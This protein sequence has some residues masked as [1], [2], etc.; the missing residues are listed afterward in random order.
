MEDKQ[1]MRI[2]MAACALTL[3]AGLNTG[4]TGPLIPKIAQ[5]KGIDLDL[6][7]SIVSVSACGSMLMLLLGKLLCE[8]LGSRNSLRLAAVIAGIGMVTVSFGPGLVVL[9]IGAF[10]IGCGT[11][12]NSIASTTSV[13]LS[14][15]ASSAAALNRV[16]LFFGIGA[17]AGPLIAWAGLSSHWSY[18][19]VYLFGAAFAFTCALLLKIQNPGKKLVTESEPITGNIKKPVLWLFALV[20]YLYVGMEVSSAAWLFTFLQKY[21][22]L[23]LALASI[24]MTVLWAGLTLG[25]TISVFLCGRY[26]SIKITLMGM[27][28]AASSLLALACFSNLGVATLAIVLLLGLGYGPI[29][30]NVLAAANEH[31]MPDTTTTS[32]VVITTGAVGGIT[33]PL[34]A[35]YGFTHLSWQMGMLFLFAVCSS[36][37]ALYLLLLKITARKIQS[38]GEPEQPEK[39]EKPETDMQMP[40]G[41]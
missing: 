9:A 30:P 2:I 5:S 3:L 27:A 34:L 37:L 14:D 13:L 35:G 4:W 18:H 36:M 22:A 7:G 23:D 6:A 38:T 28:L 17:L 39:P 12:L 24:S 16:N 19:V 1:R 32:S 41:V 11:G 10:V 20:I 33:L 40:V 8:K 25:R 26:S 15:T 21:S 31:F 29:F